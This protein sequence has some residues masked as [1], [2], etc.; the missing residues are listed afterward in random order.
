MCFYVIRIRVGILGLFVGTV[1]FFHAM[2]LEFHQ[3]I[4][5]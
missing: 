3:S 4:V 1:P 2:S 5:F